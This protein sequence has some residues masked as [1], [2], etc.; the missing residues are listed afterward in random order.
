MNN[1]D[2]PFCS[3]SKRQKLDTFLV[4]AI[5]SFTQ[6]KKNPTTSQYHYI[7]VVTLYKSIRYIPASQTLRFP[8]D[9]QYLSSRILE[10]TPCTIINLG[11]K[12]ISGFP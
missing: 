2:S 11:T 7:K 12:R 8:F 6:H 9:E 3:N 4:C 5:L 10:L 1:L